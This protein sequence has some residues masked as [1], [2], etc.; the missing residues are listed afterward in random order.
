MNTFRKTTLSDESDNGVRININRPCPPGYYKKPNGKC[1]KISIDDEDDE[2]PS[3]EKNHVSPLSLDGK[4]SSNHHRTPTI[5]RIA[6]VL[7]KPNKRCKKGTRK[8]KDGICVPKNT[9]TITNNDKSSKD[10]GTFSYDGKQST[11]NPRTSTKRRISSVVAKPR[12]QKKKPVAVTTI[13]GED[14]YSKV[15]TLEEVTNK[16]HTLLEMNSSIKVSKPTILHLFNLIK[17]YNPDELRQRNEDNSI[18][19][20]FNAYDN[21]QILL[22][23]FNEI[24]EASINRTR[25]SKKKMVT[26]QI[27]Q[28]VIENDS[29]LNELL[30]PLR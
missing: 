26:I 22:Y 12:T 21:R 9:E 7:T 13:S 19:L 28:S 4:P 29:Q 1:Y 11:K 20:P 15:I 18:M 24:M 3:P 30:M 27:I 5:R 2:E 10:N 6:D 14:V 8:N 16:T 25:D 17:K 23:L